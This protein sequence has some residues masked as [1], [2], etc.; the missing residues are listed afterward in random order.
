MKS[1]DNFNK[2]WTTEIS[3][4]MGLIDVILSTH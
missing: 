1:V 3:L 4:F 2:L